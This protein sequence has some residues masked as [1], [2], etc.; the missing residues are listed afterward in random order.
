LTERAT[1]QAPKSLCS[2]LRPGSKIAGTEIDL[3][4][5]RIDVVEDDPA[6]G[7]ALGRL[8]LAAGF[9]V[10][11]F[12][13]AEALLESGAAKDSGCLVVDIHLPGISGLE[14]RRRLVE[15]GS[16]ARVIFITANEDDQIRE[17]AIRSGADAFFIKPFAGRAL[18]NA[19]RSVFRTH[20]AECGV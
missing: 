13:S 3:A 20:P 15:S 5:E 1:E 9:S 7:E 12:P 6:M 4:S 11:R 18:I 16:R 17:A 10:S 19:L 2:L 8:L 14:L